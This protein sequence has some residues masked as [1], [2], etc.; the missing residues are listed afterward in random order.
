MISYFHMPARGGEVEVTAAAADNVAASL[1]PLPVVSNSIGAGLA[2]VG[3]SPVHLN[4]PEDPSIERYS[5][6]ARM[7]GGSLSSSTIGLLL[8]IISAP[9][10]AC[11]RAFLAFA[12]TF[13]FS[14]FSD[15]LSCDKLR[16]EQW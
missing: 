3:S 9:Y 15:Q 12:D 16:H 2:F 5:R 14:P 11:P 1:N 10:I 7:Q 8:E 13:A 4:M 6:L